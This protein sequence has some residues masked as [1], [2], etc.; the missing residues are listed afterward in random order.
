[1]HRCCIGIV[2]PRPA[3]TSTGDV[4]INDVITGDKTCSNCKTGVTGSV[5]SV[6]PAVTVNSH[7]SCWVV[8]WQICKRDCRSVV[9]QLLLLLVFVSLT[10]TGQPK[11]MMWRFAADNPSTLS[12]I[13]RRAGPTAWNP[14]SALSE[15]FFLALWLGSIR[16]RSAGRIFGFPRLYSPRYSWGGWRGRRRTEMP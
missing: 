7:S 1:M 15:G 9:N 13:M 2:A 11:C 5:V 12:C 4:M 16:I 10:I 8:S 3:V 6:A 14:R